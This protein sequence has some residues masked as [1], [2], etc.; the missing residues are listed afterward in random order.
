M[1]FAA[2]V[3]VGKNAYDMG[4]AA[5]ARA[6]AVISPI[7]TVALPSRFTTLAARACENQTVSRVHVSSM[8]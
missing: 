6:A 3:S 2:A 4:P 7:V 5:V 8:A 1:D